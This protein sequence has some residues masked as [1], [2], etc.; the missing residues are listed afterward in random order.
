MSTVYTPTG[1]T[2]VNSITLPSDGDSKS[3]ASVNVPLEAL[4][5]NV[6]Y[7]QNKAIFSVI[8][9][10]S[11][12]YSSLKSTTLNYYDPTTDYVASSTY[13]V[14]AGNQITITFNGVLNGAD[15]AQDM[16]L[17][18]G[19][20]SGISTVH[21]FNGAEYFCSQ[22]AANARSICVAGSAVSSITTTI[23]PLVRIKTTTG[24]LMILEAPYSFTGF[25]TGV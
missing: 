7:L 1:T 18:L 17:Q 11:T 19:Y 24:K 10:C 22:L 2:F 23:S 9:D 25:I 15:D 13:S 6:K 8:S 14:S 21:I 3:A 16:Y 12:G 4:A 20:R 5:E